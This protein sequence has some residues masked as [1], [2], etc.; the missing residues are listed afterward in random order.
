MLDARDQASGIFVQGAFGWGFLPRGALFPV[1]DRP[2]PPP[3]QRVTPL[4]PRRALAQAPFAEAM[5]ALILTDARLA[6][7]RF[8]AAARSPDRSEL[9]FGSDGAGVVR[10]DPATGG[11]NRLVVGLIAARA[12]AGA[13]APG[14]GWGASAGGGGGGGGGGLVPGGS[15][16]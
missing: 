11:W 16:G 13:A 8:T 7:Y 6:S 9:F 12:G 5:R 15:A 14:G 2:L 4:D 1:Q 10:V 3:G